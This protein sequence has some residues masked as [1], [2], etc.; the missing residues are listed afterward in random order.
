MNETL[1]AETP[2]T[3]EERKCNPI[4]GKQTY[5]QLKVIVCSST[6]LVPHLYSFSVEV[7]SSFYLSPVS[8]LF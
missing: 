7:F 4:E 1:D 8:I 2:F 5:F 3:F 6:I